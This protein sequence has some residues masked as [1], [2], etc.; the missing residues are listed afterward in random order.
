MLRLIEEEKVFDPALNLERDAAYWKEPKGNRAR[1]WR[2][3]RSVVLGRFLK[4]EDEVYLHKAEEMGIPV[5]KRASGGGAVYHDLGNLNYSFYLDSGDLS[6]SSIGDSLKALSYP[7]TALLDSLGLPWKWVP[8]NNVY[9]E[10]RKISGSA[11]ARRR[12]RILHH[13]T[14]LVDCDLETM[15]SLLRPG[16]R[17]RIAPVIN[18]AEVVPGIAVER[19]ERMLTQ[20]LPQETGGQP[21]IFHIGGQASTSGP[22]FL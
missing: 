22:S 8:P 11:Q 18:L 16:G 1:V 14:L 15:R 6:S 10:G 20:A 2:N 9:V 12:G 7:V 19:M 5:L 13:G 17:S 21:S 3:D 4:P